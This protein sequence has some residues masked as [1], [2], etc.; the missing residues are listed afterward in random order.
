MLPAD[1]LRPVRSSDRLG[2]YEVLL[3]IA[4]GG[5]A[6]VYLAVGVGGSGFERQVAIKLIHPHLQSDPDLVDS[7]LNGVFWGIHG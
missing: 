6:S 7:L 2:R 1:S 5:M 3:P 4:S